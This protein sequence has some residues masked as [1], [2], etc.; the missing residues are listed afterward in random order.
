MAG[1]AAVVGLAAPANASATVLYHSYNYAEAC[2]YVSQQGLLNHTWVA[3]YCDEVF[4]SHYSPSGGIVPG[5][6]N[7]YVQYS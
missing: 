3:S 6:Y 5:L 2:N 4:P 1:T 7:L